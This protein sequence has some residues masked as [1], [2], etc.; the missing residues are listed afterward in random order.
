MAQQ[1]RPD[2]SGSFGQAVVLCTCRG[3]TVEKIRH[4]LRTCAK[5]VKVL[6]QR[7][8]VTVLREPFE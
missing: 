4:Q 7:S 6:N 8:D 3:K 2:V 5:S 1:R